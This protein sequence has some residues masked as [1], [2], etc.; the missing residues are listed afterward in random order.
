MEFM[1][2]VWKERN[3]PLETEAAKISKT[4]FMREI[5]SFFLLKWTYG[6]AERGLFS[7]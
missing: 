2:F 6:A 4:D 1:Y 7:K 3:F 5:Q